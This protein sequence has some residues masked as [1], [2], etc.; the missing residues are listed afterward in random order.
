MSDDS[1]LQ[2]SFVLAVLIL[3][4]REVNAECERSGL[5]R[6]QRETNSSG[7]VSFTVPVGG[8]ILD[9][10]CLNTPSMLFAH[11]YPLV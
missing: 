1:D 4:G 5:D 3:R 2:D 11:G 7:I 6:S 8:W 9:F 10:S